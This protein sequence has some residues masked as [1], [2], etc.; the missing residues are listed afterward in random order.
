MEGYYEA[1]TGPTKR[2]EMCNTDR[3]ARNSTSMQFISGEN[4]KMSRG[5]IL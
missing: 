1:G 2:S 4:T 3:N 5:R